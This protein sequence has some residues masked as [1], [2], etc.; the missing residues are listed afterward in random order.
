MITTTET[1]HLRALLEQDEAWVLRARWVRWLREGQVS[2]TVAISSMPHDDRIAACAW[3]RQQR[4]VLHDTVTGGLR[5]P[6]GWIE[7]RPLYGALCPSGF[8]G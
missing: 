1:D 8:P 6:D 4:H 5:A 3:L 2:D 7:E